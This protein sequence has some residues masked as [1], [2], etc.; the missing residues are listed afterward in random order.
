[1]LP[2]PDFKAYTQVEQRKKAFIAFIKPSIEF[3]NKQLQ[4]MCS[5]LYQLR[6]TSYLI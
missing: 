2:K 3:A 5:R 1:M 6:A 4:M